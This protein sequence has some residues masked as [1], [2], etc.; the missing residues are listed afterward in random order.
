MGCVSAPS[1]NNCERSAYFISLLFSLGAL[2]QPRS[3][4]LRNSNVFRCPSERTQTHFRGAK[5]DCQRSSQT[6]VGGYH[7]ESVR[8]GLERGIRGC[9]SMTLPVHCH[10]PPPPC[11]LAVTP[12]IA[13][14]RGWKSRGN[15]SQMPL[16][17]GGLFGSGLGRSRPSWSNGRK[18]RL[19]AATTSLFFRCS[20][21]ASSWYN[22]SLPTSNHTKEKRM[23]F[24]AAMLGLVLLSQAGWAQ[25]EK[26]YRR[27]L[28]QEGLSATRSSITAY[29]EKHRLAWADASRHISKLG[30]DDFETR[31]QATLALIKGNAVPRGA[32]AESPRSRRCRGATTSPKRPRRDEGQARL[33]GVPF[34][35]DVPSVGVDNRNKPTRRLR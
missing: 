35:Y 29:F 3:L 14:R 12:H 33:G 34:E 7:R 9:Q 10:A 28:E 18:G 23:R 22:R 27:L 13:R 6:S 26:A 15:E 8:R 17:S 20:L 2:T 19:G 4:K 21:E 30:D 25:E 32:A 16:P 24:L 11:R 31:D 5:D 1:Q